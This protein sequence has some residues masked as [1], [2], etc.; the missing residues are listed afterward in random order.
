[1]LR[2]ED[3]RSQLAN[4]ASPDAFVGVIRSSEPE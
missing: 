3:L 1:M 4:A 2:R